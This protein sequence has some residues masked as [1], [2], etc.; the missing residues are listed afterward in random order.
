[1]AY[2]DTNNLNSNKSQSF[3]LTNSCVNLIMQ[4]LTVFP[5]NQPTNTGLFYYGLGLFL[6]LFKHIFTHRIQRKLYCE[7][8]LSVSFIVFLTRWSFFGTSLEGSTSEDNLFAFPLHCPGLLIHQ[9]FHS[10]LP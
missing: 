8:L 2:K 1:M 6:F 4:H 7:I 9:H 10:V 5:F 3:K